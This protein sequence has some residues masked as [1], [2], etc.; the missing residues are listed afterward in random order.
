MLHSSGWPG[1]S[2]I[3]PLIV[4]GWSGLHHRGRGDER[5][6]VARVVERELTGMLTSTGRTEKAQASLLL[7][8]VV[9]AMRTRVRVSTLWSSCLSRKP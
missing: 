7:E 6:I 2:W 3:L 1:G 9:G 4:G 8:K 5:G